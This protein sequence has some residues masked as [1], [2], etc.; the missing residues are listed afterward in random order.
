M[1]EPGLMPPDRLPRIR[2]VTSSHRRCSRRLPRCQP[3]QPPISL[4]ANNTILQLLVAT[5]AQQP[6]R[7]CI[8]RGHARA[9]LQFPTYIRLQDITLPWVKGMVIHLM[10]RRR[11]LILV[12]CTKPTADLVRRA[13]SCRLSLAYPICGLPLLMLVQATFRRFGTNP[14]RSP[15]PMTGIRDLVRERSAR[16]RHRPRSP[17]QILRMSRT[18]TMKDFL[19]P[20]LLRRGKSSE[21]WQMW[22]SHAHPRY[23]SSLL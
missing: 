19:P 2:Q 15:Q 5:M 6:S 23:R 7:S 12:T 17:A 4:S 18:M 21:V 13:P 16:H 14:M 9:A 22:R 1:C 11:G 8:L 20:V 3:R 10:H